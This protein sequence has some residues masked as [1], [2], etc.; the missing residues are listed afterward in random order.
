MAFSLR[1]KV[2]AIVGALLLLTGVFI[3]IFFPLRQEREMS[4][5]L[6][7][8]TLVVS[9]MTAQNVA[10]ALV[11]DDTE[12]V[13]ASLGLLKVVADVQFAIT[14]KDGKESGGYTL[15]NI[16]SKRQQVDAAVQAKE[17][18]SVIDDILV[19]VVPIMGEKGVIGT[20]VLGVS[21][22]KLLADVRQSRVI[23][24]AVGLGIVLIGGLMIWLVISRLTKPLKELAAAAEQVAHGR[25][26]IA[27][28]VQSRDEIGVLATG[29]NM[30]VE[31]VRHSIAGFQAQK[32]AADAL[33]QAAEEIKN[34]TIEQQS[35]LEESTRTI[36]DAMQRFAFGDLTVQVESNG[37]QDDIN[38]IFVGFNR[39]IA[40]V[41]DL[42]EKVINN[43]AKTNDIAAHI[44]SASGEMAATSEEQ[45]SQVMYIATSVEDMARSVAENAHQSSQINSLTQRN[46]TNA[47][48]GARVVGA[49]VKKIEEI[50]KVVN[51]AS[52]VVEKLG[53]SSAEIGE[54]VQVIEEI[55]DQTNLLAL[56]AAIE[57]ARA[58]EQGR[59]FAVV[60]DE[61]RKL[62]ERTATATKQISQT[63]KQIQRDTEQAVIGMKRGD[64]EVVEGL[65]LAKQAGN[66]L[67]G[68][69]TDSLEVEGMMKGS[70][71][72]LQQ[73]SSS[74]AGISQNIEQVSASIHETTSSLSAIANA[75]E[76]LRTL[77]ESLQ[78]LVS[79]FEVGDSAQPALES[80]KTKQ[81]Y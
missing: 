7:A 13:K 57:A 58:G 15:E 44:S 25:T 35:Y 77:T 49:A 79:H 26:D 74:A 50:A 39:S 20:L 9:E 33:A 40:S 30:M 56:N 12:A 70:S 45:A 36:L 24:I 78:D 61:V 8:Q 76:S 43:V 46:G 2:S 38:K 60:A 81:L 34:K 10:S 80:P 48:E 4:K 37:R 53:N 11:F 63:I 14:I 3:A 27:V 18:L 59:G 69:V 1:T 28:K 54:I 71:N 47:S 19:A 16:G 21:R 67:R 17:R 29:F 32:E 75:T 65:T 52:A 6:D 5:Y 55:A 41:R 72:A 42:V 73:Q 31:N 51:D 23:A 66:A 22:E 62:A 64:K 68:I